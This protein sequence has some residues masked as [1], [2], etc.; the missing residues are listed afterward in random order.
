MIVSLR[1]RLLSG[2]VVGT[3]LLLC[4]FCVIVY[5]VTRRTLIS[6]FDD[7]LLSTAKMLS[8]VVEDEG[9]RHGGEDGGEDGGEG[10]HERE[11]HERG[12]GEIELGFEFDVRMTPAF[13][14]LNGG[15]YYQFWN[16]KGDAVERS[17]SL[18]ESNL[19]YY[20]GE[21]VGPVYLRCVLAGGEV[22]RVVCY[23]FMPRTERDSHLENKAVTLVLGR[24]ASE[25]YDFLGF[26]R[27]LLVNCS[28]VI[29]ALSSYVAAKVTRIGLRPV[30]TL[31]SEIASVDEYALDQSFFEEAY[32]A[33]LVPICECLNGLMERIKSSFERERRFNADVAHELRTPLAGIQTAIEVCL[34]RNR[35]AD[36]YVGALEGC[37]A[38][39]MT[40][41][42]LVSTLLALSRLDAEQISFDMQ[43]IDI[44]CLI[45]DHWQD[46]SEKA[47]G[48]NLSFENLVGDDVC[49]F[50]D[51]DHLGMIISNVLDNAVEYCD[52]GG[53]IRV[54][55]VES[56]GAMLLSISNTGCV[57][58]QE[59]VGHVFDMF[60]R[61]DSARTDTGVHSGIGLA[62]VRKIA[63]VLGVE[64]RVAI[65]DD[66][67]FTIWLELP[68]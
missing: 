49:C 38:I 42:R 13:N 4:V 11:D 33:E 27:W 62:V 50:A 54:V 45:E 34:S 67:V 20:G 65:E 17:P 8:A 14:N 2:V 31:A 18:G 46:F 47:D 25:V 60:W 29:V 57:L 68:I 6:N 26:F 5:T 21:S 22:G 37:L 16:C 41:N 7:S 12:D 39:S 32:P 3:V 1:A 66:S 51:K 63:K 35:K 24:D 52:G 53:Q 10:E 48:R 56:G 15:G 61:A 28:L 43:N 59:D 9:E 58:S 23:K 40:M 19:P 64:V 36:E 30:H 55:A 44:K